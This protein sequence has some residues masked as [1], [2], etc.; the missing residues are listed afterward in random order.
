MLPIIA[1]RVFASDLY[2][3]TIAL[4]QFLDK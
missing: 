1:N 3:K 2:T 4:A